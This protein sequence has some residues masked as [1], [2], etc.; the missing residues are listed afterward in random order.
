MCM[1]MMD[2]SGDPGMKLGKGSSDL[3]TISLVLFPETAVAEACRQRIQELRH[4]LGMK[5][6]GQAASF[7]FARWT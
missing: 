7:H 4:E 6:S 3:F 2:E 5:L 1:A